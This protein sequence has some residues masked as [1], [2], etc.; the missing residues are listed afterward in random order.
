[1]SAHQTQI[2]DKIVQQVDFFQMHTNLRDL[3]HMYYTD[4]PDTVDWGSSNSLVEAFPTIKGR[5]KMIVPMALIFESDHVDGKLIIINYWRLLKADEQR[6]VRDAV[7]S[8]YL[9]PSQ[10]N[11]RI[12]LNV[13][14]RTVS[15]DTEAVP[16]LEPPS[17][18]IMAADP[19]GLEGIL[20][21]DHESFLQA[22]QNLS[23]RV[24]FFHEAAP[25]ENMT[26]LKYAS[27]PEDLDWSDSVALDRSFPQFLDHA[28]RDVPVCLL[29]EAETNEERLVVVN[30]WRYL[31]SIQQPK[32]FQELRR[33]YR[34]PTKSKDP[35]R[36]LQEV[37]DKRKERQNAPSWG[38]RG[39]ATCQQLAQK[40]KLS[41]DMIQTANIEQDLICKSDGCI[42]P[43]LCGNNGFCCLHRVSF[44]P[45][46]GKERRKRGHFLIGSV[47][48]KPNTRLCSCNSDFCVGIGF[49]ENMIRFDVTRLPTE[50]QAEIWDAVMPKSRKTACLAPW[51]FHPQH[52]LL[53][54][55]G[56]WIVTQNRRSTFKNPVTGSEWLGT[57]PPTYSV[58][59]TLFLYEVVPIVFDSLCREATK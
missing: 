44:A 18:K 25:L 58:E 21:K 8:Y 12:N 5:G 20:I 16:S 27:V 41:C 1:M 4:I 53:Q 52:R 28:S 42:Y 22:V 17:T 47:Y 3:D 40:L 56:S 23:T 37:H 35:M 43:A 38:F 55:D 36:E 30:W 14:T 11:E 6:K 19:D 45:L 48:T 15:H 39:I 50:L 10:G 49:S 33:Y 29:L 32:A 59:G 46:E 54:P 31:D 57:P 7:R 9:R 24:R 2:R 26:K 13:T 34:A 51:H